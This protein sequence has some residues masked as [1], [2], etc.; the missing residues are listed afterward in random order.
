M[1]RGQLMAITDGDRGP[2]GVYLLA[3]YVVDDTDFFGDGQITGGRSG[4]RRPAGQRELEP[5]VG[6]ADG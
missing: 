6:P 1:L 3:I 5:R 2:L 4:A